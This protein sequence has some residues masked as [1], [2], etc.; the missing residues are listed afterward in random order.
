M[1]RQ[2]QRF[3]VFQFEEVWQRMFVNSVG[4][5]RPQ[6]SKVYVLHQHAVRKH[7]RRD[8]DLISPAMTTCSIQ[9]RHLCDKARGR[10][11][12]QTRKML[13]RH[14]R[15]MCRRA[16][17]PAMVNQQRCAERQHDLARNE[18]HLSASLRYLLTCEY[19]FPLRLQR[20][21]AMGQETRRSPKVPLCAFLV[22]VQPAS[23]HTSRRARNHSKPLVWYRHPLMKESGEPVRQSGGPKDHNGAL[24]GGAPTGTH[25]PSRSVPSPA[26]RSRPPAH[27]PSVYG[28]SPCACR[29][30]A[31]R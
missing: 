30:P 19:R 14:S 15:S 13:D 23:S 18:R 4:T 17:E 7:Q 25:C 6:N 10:T 24:R 21:G 26:R 9:V 28:R 3:A 11:L 8:F 1:S 27:R 5:R 20:G 29:S 12:E 31:P 2:P 16:T 22:S